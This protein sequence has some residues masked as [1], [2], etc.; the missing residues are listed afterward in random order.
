MNRKA[1]WKS[2]RTSSGG[3]VGLAVLCLGLL[4]FGAV[5][6]ALG[7]FWI[8]GPHRVSAQTELT[9]GVP[10]SDNMTT[11]GDTNYYE[12]GVGASE[13]ISIILDGSTSSGYNQNQI[14]VRFGDLPT[15]S[16][17]DFA[18]VLAS[19][20]DQAVLIPSTSAGTYYILAYCAYYG[21]CYGCGPYGY[22]ITVQSSSTFPT[23]TA[24]DISDD[25]METSGDA[26]W[27]QVMTGGG[28]TLSIIL[29]GSTSSGYNQNQIYVRYGDLPTTEVYDFT[30]VLSDSPDQAV[31]IQSTSAGT[32]Y[33]L[34]YC[35]SYGSC[36]GCGPYGYTITVQSSSTFPA[37]AT[38]EAVSDQMQTSGDANWYQVMTGAGETL[39]IILD[40]S[41]SSGYNQNQVYVRYGD[42][43]TTEV[44][45]FTG[46]LSDS[47]DQAVRI[48]STSA[49]TYYILAYCTYYGSCY[50]CGP[51]GYTITVQS[52][53]TFPALPTGEAV[54]D[55]ME[56]SGDANWY[57]VMTGTAETLSI[58]LDG[59]TSSGYNQNQIYVRYGDLPTTAAYDL[60]G[61][62]TES[63]D[64]A[65]LIS[66]TQAGTYYI[67]AYCTYY[68]SCY[69][70]GPYGYTITAT[71][72][73]GGNNAPNQPSN[74]SPANAAVRVGLT[75]TLEASVFSDSNSGDT[76]AASQWQITTTAGN[77]SS[78]A[79]DSGRDGSNLTSIT[80]PSSVLS[81]G[82]TYH[83]RVRHQD[84]NAV[85]SAWSSETS[86][87]TVSGANQPPAAPVNGSP[88][89]SAAGVDVA[90]TLASSDFSDPDVGDS[91]AA[92]Q[93]QVTRIPGDYSNAV[94]DSGTDSADMTEVSIPSEILEY[95]T[96]YYWRVRYQDS[97]GNWSAWSEE[98]S[99]VTASAPPPAS[100]E[101]ES[102]IGSV[103]LPSEVSTDPGVVGT[104][105]VFAMIFAIVFYAAASLF[106][107]TF[108]EN[109]AVIRQWTGRVSGRLS[110]VDRYVSDKT[111]ALPRIPGK[112]G[113]Y[114]RAAVIVIVSALLYS[115]IDRTFGFNLRGLA[116]FLA[117][118]VSV[119]VVT[120]AYEGIQVV[121]MS[122]RFSIPAGFKLYWVA[123]LIA[124]VCVGTSLA[125][126]FHPGIIYGFVGTATILSV[127]R[128]EKRHEAVAVLVGGVV[129][130]A[131]A[132]CAFYARGFT[133]NAAKEGDRFWV[134]LV[135]GILAG[136]VV[137]GLEGLLF[138]LL[139]LPFVDGGKV[140]AWKW[141]VAFAALCCVVFFFTWYL[142]NIDNTLLDAV[143]DMKVVAMA[144]LMPL[145]L[146]VSGVFWL[147]FWLRGRRL[148]RGEAAPAPVPGG[149]VGGVV[150]L[151]A[152]ESGGLVRT[153]EEVVQTIFSEVEKKDPHT[154]SHQRRVTD[155]AHAIAV[156]LGMSAEQSRAV[157]LAGMLHD[158]GKTLVP[159]DL[160]NKP[161]R[162]TD[163]EFDTIKRHPGAGSERLREMEVP[164]PIVDIVAQHHERLDG[165][166]YPSGLKGD[167]SSLGA[168][169]LAVAD[170]VAAMTSDRPHRPAFSLEQAL[171][172]IAGKR[173]KLYDAGV[174]NACLAVFKK[175]SFR[176]AEQGM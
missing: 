153:V 109:Y 140:A 152:K 20:P 118:A 126:D 168:R 44:Y 73:G 24:G 154:A 1:R 23:L 170:V 163:A 137:M 111:S 119:A 33:I 161:G 62:L 128:P 166:G 146:L 155:L 70:C 142:I 162:L 83:W 89:D 96:T 68:G 27:Y 85:W 113:I 51:Y 55:Q 158:L 176:F 58:I 167:Q 107:G 124:A 175:G 25:Q 56:T 5:A 138:A 164:E 97:N 112:V 117:L 148:R 80:I 2:V 99:F 149:A 71:A 123:L 61:G 42:L 8:D 87:S 143:R 135:D 9:I 17:Y 15:P 16:V 3:R 133:P 122:R 115:F 93:W 63:P 100:S 86:F 84:N 160:L 19:S 145:A 90:P 110:A 40:G 52:S 53:S 76:H 6:S 116:I 59:S 94:F 156:E 60:V 64:Q 98:S 130:F 18:G 66:G 34:A 37:L 165:S 12:F 32:Y 28:E 136:T 157:R 69:G 47:P 72:S 48:Q 95:S 101:D 10:F 21:S 92:A 139:P 77:Y 81:G 172:E 150:A 103:P 46:V 7:G 171:N 74:L 105:V 147:Y 169:I 174:V 4:I 144:A 104:N 49:G 102:L 11:S 120:L 82:T 75:P 29:D 127:K 26:N 67:L 30:G 31:Q 50:G 54:S 79:F 88:S 14:Y 173:D 57:Q 121:V 45:D 141:W 129:L 38:G 106:N 43:P 151:P 35:T 114:L 132:I 78:A 36:Y 13:I 108:K 125:V 39:S 22:T 65:L 41:T 159:S 134:L 131:A 91:Q